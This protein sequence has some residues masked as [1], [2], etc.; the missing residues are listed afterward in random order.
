M[1]QKEKKPARDSADRI[2]N[3]VV[4]VKAAANEKLENLHPQAQAKTR[5]RSP[6]SAPSP[7]NKGQKKT[8]WQVQKQIP[9]IFSPEVYPKS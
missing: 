3:Q 5:C 8:D 1:E 2:Q 6:P 9:Q 4:Y 7:S